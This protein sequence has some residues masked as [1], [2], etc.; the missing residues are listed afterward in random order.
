M[1]VGD[2]PERED[3]ETGAPFLGPRGQ[4]FERALHAAGLRREIVYLTFAV[5]HFVPE[6][7]SK[8]APGAPPQ[9]DHV[10]ACRPWLDAEVR[11]VRPVTVVAL[12][13]VAGWALLG[14]S[15]RDPRRRGQILGRP[16]GRKLILTSPLQELRTKGKATGA[17][18]RLVQDIR[19][20]GAAAKMRE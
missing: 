17:F 2:Q 1:F 18:D 3:V 10:R 20:A 15:G 13:P 6:G 7:A 11:A 5:K 12:G 4:A 8:L 9:A 16:D 19:R 14:P